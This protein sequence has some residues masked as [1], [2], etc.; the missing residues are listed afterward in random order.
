MLIIRKEQQEVFAPLMRQGFEQRMVAH[1]AK[2]CPQ[3]F[4]K[5]GEPSV[6]KMALEGEEK[7]A[8][9]GI[10]EEQDIARYLELTM[11]HGPDWEAASGLRWAREILSDESLSGTAK[12]DI[13]YQRM[14]SPPEP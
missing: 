8:A 1:L 2:T 10:T 6:R 14:S 13:V 3:E 12:M 11:R 7:A 4:Q 9:H 5:M